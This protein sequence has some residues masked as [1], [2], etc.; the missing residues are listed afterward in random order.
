MANPVVKSIADNGLQFY[1]TLVAQQNQAFGENQNALQLLS[2][3]WAPVLSS[4]QVPYGFSPQL[5]AL[6]QANVMDT[7]AQ[8][9]SNATSAAAL[10]EKQA[11]GG[12]NVAPTGADAQINADIAATGQQAIAKGLQGEKIAG[13]QQGLNELEGGTDAELGIA[14]ASNPSSYSQSA[15]GAGDMAEKAGA[16]EFKENFETSSPQAIMGEISQGVGLAGQI[17]GAAMGIGDVGSMFSSSMSGAGP[18]AGQSGLPG[19]VGP[20]T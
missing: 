15:V 10:A 7:G 14:G 3:A 13:Y 9:E 5:D 20:Y 12:A 6:L 11:A 18:T 1:N 16:E 4:G 17:A 19:T 2:K 8:A